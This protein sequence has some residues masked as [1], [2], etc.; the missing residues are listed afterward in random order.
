MPSKFKQLKR[1]A[2]ACVGL[3]TSKVHSKVQRKLLFNL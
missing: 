2:F 3:D 1:K